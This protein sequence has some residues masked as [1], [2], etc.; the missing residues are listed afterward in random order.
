MDN[1]RN[2]FIRNLKYFRGKKGLR[3]L[4]LSLEINKGANY[5]N[6]IEN[7]KYF[8]GPETI[9]E[10]AKI[11]EIKP[12]QLFDENSCIENIL[13]DNREKLKNEIIEKQELYTKGHEYDECYETEFSSWHEGEANTLLENRIYETRKSNIRRRMLLGRATPIPTRKRGT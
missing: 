13:E 2:I 11:L 12:M 9:Q 4:D 3:Q 5:I 6:S 7:A 8:P 1:L 10:I